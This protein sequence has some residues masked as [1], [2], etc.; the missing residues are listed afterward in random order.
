MINSTPNNK[1]YH[2]GI[3][4]PQ[5]KDKVL[6][7]NSQGGLPY[8]SS[9]EK[10]IMIWLDNNP[11]ITLWGSECISI[12]YQQ[13]HFDNG[14]IKLKNHTYYP[15]FYYKIRSNDGSIKDVIAEVKPMKEF[16]MVRQLQEKNINIPQKTTTKK[17]KNLE[18]DVKMAHKNLNKWETMIK[19]CDK[20]GWEFII[21]T[22]EILKKMGLL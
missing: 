6:K 11:S 19:F 12:P 4:I 1:N 15:D 8:R 13:T 5:N 17:L 18:Y 10:K 9:W 3:Y 22:E 16:L 21:I 20:K 2:Q 14:D 7:L